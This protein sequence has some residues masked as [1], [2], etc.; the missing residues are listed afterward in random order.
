MGVKVKNYQIH[1]TNGLYSNMT[2]KS[3]KR[4][5]FFFGIWGVEKWS[6]CGFFG[7]FVCICTCVCV[8]ACVCSLSRVCALS[9]VS[10]CACLR[11]RVSC[12]RSISSIKNNICLPGS[13]NVLIWRTFAYLVATIDLD[14]LCTYIHIQHHICPHVTPSKQNAV[15]NFRV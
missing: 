9:R 14:K 10:A 15:K 12:V 8:S 1:I 2:M 5:W 7:V 13:K 6:F 3:Q 11:V 4:K